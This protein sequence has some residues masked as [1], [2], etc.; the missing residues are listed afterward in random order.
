[1]K[2]K[3]HR[4]GNVRGLRSLAAFT[5]I[6]IA[7]ALAVIGFALVAIIGVLPAGMSVQRD[8]RES[9]IVN[10]DANFL[11]DAITTG[12]G[13]DDLTNHVIA[14]TNH[15]TFYDV[16]SSGAIVPGATGYIGYTLSGTYGNVTGSA[17]VLTNGSN[18]IALLSTPKYA[19]SGGGFYSNYVTADFRA[20]TGSLADQGTSQSAQS[21][22]FAYRI[23]P[24]V[25]DFFAA[26]SNM[27]TNDPNSLA[28]P[29]MQAVAGESQNDFS[30]VR[31]RFRW[32]IYGNGTVGISRLTFRTAVSGYRAQGVSVGTPGV[33][34]GGWLFQNGTY[35]AAQ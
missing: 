16:K 24:E 28:D 31:L 20:F 27:P 35:Y 4:A 8:N 10:F 14:I 5:M 34:T 7:L 9:T 2:L 29:V 22:A 11:M 33:A 15:Y 26:A 23:F 6:E 19:Q 18:I 1:M 30:Q 12:T 21:F 32:P 17:T 25:V 3:L 13:V